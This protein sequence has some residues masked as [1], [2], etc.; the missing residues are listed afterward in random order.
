[1]EIRNA[2]CTDRGDIISLLYS[3]GPEMYDFLFKTPLHEAREFLQYEFDTGRGFWGFSNVTV[4]VVDGMVIGTG[5]FFGGKS[6]DTLSFQTVINAFKF[7]GLR[8]IG[9]ILFRFLCAESVMKHPKKGEIYL[10]N[11]AV[12]P[13][14]RG[15]GIGSEF[16]QVHIQ[17]FREVGYHIFGLDVSVSNP[18]AEKL[19]KNYGFESICIKKLWGKRS[20]CIVPDTKKMELK[21]H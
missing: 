15:M 1:M 3:A 10:S 20:D 17:R 21:L 4:V 6:F 16:L 2:Q 5:C 7:Y 11:F 19:Y 8:E 13:T 9:T 18:R 12:N 14:Q